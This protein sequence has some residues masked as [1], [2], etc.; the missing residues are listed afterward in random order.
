[1]KLF[2]LWKGPTGVNQHQEPDTET[3][4]TDTHPDSQTYIKNF[5]IHEGPGNNCHKKWS[6]RSELLVCMTDLMTYHHPSGH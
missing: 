3:D 2:T 4:H 5:D 6:R 1:M